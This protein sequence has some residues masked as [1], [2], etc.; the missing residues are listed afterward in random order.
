MSTGIDFK[1][2]ARALEG[3]V[4]SFAGFASAAI[5]ATGGS[6]AAA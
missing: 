6:A 5:A 4:A 3:G 1:G 2:A